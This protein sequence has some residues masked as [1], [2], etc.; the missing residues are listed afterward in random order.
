MDKALSHR[1][2]PS[3]PFADA[4]AWPRAIEAGDAQAVRALLAEGATVNAT[5]DKGETALMRASAKG[6]A[7][8]AQILIGAGADVNARRQDGF[9]PL[10]LAVFFGH[11]DVVRLLLDAGA[12]ASAQTR[13]GTTA[14]KWAASRGFQEIV[15]LLREAEAARAHSREPEESATVESLRPAA[16]FEAPFVE[17]SEPESE[18]LPTL[19]QAS[20]PRFRSAL[21]S[22]PVMAAAIVLIIASGVAVFTL[23][24]GAQT[25]AGREQPVSTINGDSPQ[26]VI[27]QTLPPVADSGPQPAASPLAQESTPAVP[28]DA[29]A[30]PFTPNPQNVVNY[31]PP[32]VS[33]AEI[34]PSSSSPAVVSESGAGGARTSGSEPGRARA[35]DPELRETSTQARDEERVD[36]GAA[37]GTQSR[38]PQR[39]GAEMRRMTAQPP[40]PTLSDAPAPAPTPARKKVIQWP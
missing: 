37:T 18:A 21:Q 30:L 11:E 12:D 4:T 20:A 5:F 28:S 40:L 9:T 19:T 14:E 1:Q 15:V 36:E 27:P 2:P 34:A 38:A 23:R 17:P 6:Y 7:D 8:V 32:P 39:T 31:D 35:A 16:S 13:L 24:R 22:W 33:S 25:S 26:T 10:I 29:G 3:T